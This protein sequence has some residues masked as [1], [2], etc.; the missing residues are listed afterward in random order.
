MYA[1]QELSTRASPKDI[2][3][4]LHKLHPV[5]HLSFYD[6]RVILKSGF[7][8][9][10]SIKIL[11]EADVIDWLWVLYIFVWIFKDIFLFL[12]IKL[13]SF[14]GIEITWKIGT[15]FIEWTQWNLCIRLYQQPMWCMWQISSVIKGY[16]LWDLISL[17]IFLT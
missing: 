14:F 15:N 1:P 11:L 16:S 8:L 2:V 12:V 5:Y 10:E 9:S 6:N 3:S 7:F 17:K 13:I 4:F